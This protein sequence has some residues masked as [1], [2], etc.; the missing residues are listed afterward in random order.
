MKNKF[1]KWFI[2]ISW[3]T[4]AINQIVDYFLQQDFNAGLIG[5]VIGFSTIVLKNWGYEISKKNR[6]G[7][8][9]NSYYHYGIL[10]SHLKLIYKF[11]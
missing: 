2:L 1:N 6:M 9:H 8:S 5:F 7:H 10:T 4:I 11:K 3:L